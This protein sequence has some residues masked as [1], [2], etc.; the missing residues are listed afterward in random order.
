MDP[1]QARMRLAQSVSNSLIP[2]KLLLHL[3]FFGILNILNNIS[4]CNKRQL[5]LSNVVE[6]ARNAL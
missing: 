3:Q 6:V 5:G 2:G 4:I 1:H